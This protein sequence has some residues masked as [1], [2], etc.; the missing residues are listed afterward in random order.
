MLYL[1]VLQMLYV[2]YE[3]ESYIMKNLLH[4]I[5][6]LFGALSIMFVSCDVTAE[7][8]GSSNQSGQQETV[9]PEEPE[10]PEER[11][12]PQVHIKT[13][14]GADIVSKEDWLGNTTIKVIDEYG[15]VDLST[16]ASIRGRGNSTWYYP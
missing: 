1:S 16:T 11:Y 7:Q 15:E 3:F 2:F 12:I 4:T 8:N 14:G 6:L 13:P 9:K 10:E 5:L